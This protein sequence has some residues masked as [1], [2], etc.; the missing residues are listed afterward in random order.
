METPEAETLYFLLIDDQKSGP[1]LLSELVGAGMQAESLV[2]WQGLESWAR[3]GKIPKLAALLDADR[4]ERQAARR[5]DRLPDPEP[6]RRLGRLCLLANLPTAV[7]FFAGSTALLAALVLWAIVQNTTGPPPARPN[8]VLVLTA[9]VLFFFGLAATGL[10]MPCFILEAVFIAGLVRQCGALVR[11]AV[12]REPT[13]ERP[14]SDYLFGLP[15]WLSGLSVSGPGLPDPIWLT[16][17]GMQG[18]G[19]ALT[20]LAGLVIFT[21]VV[22]VAPLIFCLMKPELAMQL[23]SVVVLFLIYAAVHVPIVICSL[24]TIY[25]TGFSLNRV[26]DLYRLKV[27][28]APIG[29]GFWTS[30]CGML[31]L[32]GP[33]S[34][35]FFILLAICAR[36]TSETAAM[37]CDPESRDRIAVPLAK[38][39]PLKPAPDMIL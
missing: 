13:G 19:L 6:L 16:V 30:I 21:L 3:A 5:A 29:L 27:P 1:F 22:M 38:E 8:E 39:P 9:T 4:R 35:V 10:G 20:G 17:L 25:R 36:Q 33:F 2:W 23:V 18:G 12:P 34:L 28:W 15:K 14:L 32:A 11:A 7:L 31:I 37:I 24:C 26:I